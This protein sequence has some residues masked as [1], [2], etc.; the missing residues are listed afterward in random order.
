MMI[1]VNKRAI[2]SK[3]ISKSKHHKKSFM[4]KQYREIGSDRNH[5]NKAR[6]LEKK[7]SFIKVSSNDFNGCHNNNSQQIKYDQKMLNEPA[8]YSNHF[9]H[10][11]EFKVINTSQM[12]NSNFES[13][14]GITDSKYP[15]RAHQIKHI[16]EFKNQQKEAQKSG[17]DE[18]LPNLYKIT[19]KQ[20]II[21]VNLDNSSYANSTTHGM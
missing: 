11:S 1:P 14:M 6:K 8:L 2:K 3:N 9:P 21:D 16:S 7:D 12:D 20:E 18:P 4:R 17:R 13:R 19:E 5:L 15:N 10:F